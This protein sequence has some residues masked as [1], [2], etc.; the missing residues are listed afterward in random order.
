V[1]HANV[2]PIKPG[3]C[4]TAAPLNMCL[5]IMN[6]SC[7]YPVPALFSEHV[8]QSCLLP[9][10]VPC[11]P[12]SLIFCLK[13]VHYSHR[14]SL[15]SYVPG[16]LLSVRRDRFGPGVVIGAPLLAMACLPVTNFS[17]A[18]AGFCNDR[19]IVFRCC[20]PDILPFRLGVYNFCTF[21]TLSPDVRSSI[22]ARVV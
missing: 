22:W 9:R 1:S 2:I 21:D 11:R 16:L 15:R 3:Q 20:K 14:P 17:V 19:D 4:V 18:T 7:G 10:A 5:C 8:M 6:C 12:D 13:S